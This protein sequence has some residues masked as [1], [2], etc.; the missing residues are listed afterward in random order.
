MIRGNEIFAKEKRSGKGAFLIESNLFFNTP[1][2]FF[3]ELP[4]FSELSYRFPVCVIN[5]LGSDIIV[6]IFVAS[7]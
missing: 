7:D 6:K 2:G 5:A 4:L 3:E 1:S